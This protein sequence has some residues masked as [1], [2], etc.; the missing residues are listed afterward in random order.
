MKILPNLVLASQS[1]RR[2]LLLRQVGLRFSV[3]PSTK[4]EPKHPIK[5]VSSTH[6]HF[7]ADI[8]EFKALH[9]KAN[10]KDTII[11]GADTLV[12]IGNKVLGKPQGKQE[13]ENMLALLSGRTHTVSTAICLLQYENNLLIKKK[14]KIVR[15]KVTFQDLSKEEISWYLKKEEPYDKAGAYGIQDAAGMAFIKKIS[16]SYSN[17][18]GL[19]ID[20]TLQ[21]LTKISGKSW[22]LWT[23]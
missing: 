4:A 19:P 23:K 15:S 1:P 14:R 5:L 21:L 20:Q 16:G 2:R 17:V 22:L 13:A 3:S 11:L 18:V 12:F 6:D 9:T 8:A 10:K 7:M